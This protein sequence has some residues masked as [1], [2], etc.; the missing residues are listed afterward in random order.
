MWGALSVCNV[1]TVFA[2]L[3]VVFFVSRNIYW[4]EG[5]LAILLLVYLVPVSIPVIGGT[6]DS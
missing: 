4:P 3:L 5:V 2:N 6:R 1:N